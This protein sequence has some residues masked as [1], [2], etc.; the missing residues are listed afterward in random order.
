MVPLR[1]NRI[2]GR[3]DFRRR[4]PQGEIEKNSQARPTPSP[5]APRRRTPAAS[6]EAPASSRSA[7]QQLLQ[8]HVLLAVIT[9]DGAHED[10]DGNRDADGHEPDGQ[11]DPGALQHAGEDVPA[12]IIG[13]K[14]IDPQGRDFIGFQ[15]CDVGSRQR[16]AQLFLQPHYGRVKD[17][18]GPGGEEHADH[19]GCEKKRE[20]DHACEG[21][22]VFAQQSP[23]L[24][25][26]RASG[27]SRLLQG[28]G[29]C[30]VFSGHS[31]ILG[32]AR[33]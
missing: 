23:E 21:Q 2:Q 33:T 15:G 27:C 1:K 24:L 9:G 18:F 14:E 19:R 17:G 12:Q 16:W 7:Q 32:S 10:A 5:T 6:R 25:Q 11:G 22:T 31:R 13:S 26:A 29:G 28:C 4:K 3:G 20:D 30:D 8:A